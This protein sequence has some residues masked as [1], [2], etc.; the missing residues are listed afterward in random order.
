MG[1]LKWNVSVVCAFIFS[2][3]LVV[4]PASVLSNLHHNTCANVQEEFLRLKIGVRDLVPDKP[5]H[6]AHLAVCGKGLKHPGQRLCCTNATVEK[7]H[8]AA[9]KYLTDS[10]HSGTAFLK[11]FLMDKHQ[12][13]EERSQLFLD[14]AQNRTSVL[15][16]HMHNIP[17]TKH[18]D[19]VKDFFLDLEKYII[20]QNDNLHESVNTFFSK[21]FPSVFYYTLN[22]PSFIQMDDKYHDCLSMHAEQIRPFGKV[23]H[24]LN[25][26]LH[27]SLKRSRSFVS[28]LTNIVEAMNTTEN[29]NIDK[30]CVDAVTRLQYCSRC[31]G[32]TNVKPCHGFCLNVMRGCLSTLSDI[33]PV[34]DTLIVSMENLVSD[35]KGKGNLKN[36][37]MSID[38]SVFDGIL[39]AM[40]GG[41]RIHSKVMEHCAKTTKGNTKHQNYDQKIDTTLMMAPTRDLSH[42]SLEEVIDSVSK[43]LKDSMGMYNRI[44]DGICRSQTAYEQEM[45]S[46]QCWNGTDIGQYITEVPEANFISQAKSN[47]EVRVAVN[48]LPS[49]LALKDKLTQLRVNISSMLSHD[50]MLG[51]DPI[52]YKDMT[53]NSG[54]HQTIFITDDEDLYGSSGSGSGYSVPSTESPPTP[55]I[56]KDRETKKNKPKSS[57][58]IF[59]PSLLLLT[60]LLFFSLH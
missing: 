49:L 34:W 60:I 19:A 55:T 24:E 47:R 27:H 42:L 8:V 7:Y 50:I 46:S 17:W 31:H 26:K 11:K 10:L 35:L 37:L 22:D 1:A 51:D 53:Y 56:Y 57:A 14:E 41:P 36:A 9:N 3:S 48:T 39:E 29:I 5:H 52:D 32:H 23:P 15:L 30:N 59:S 25:K 54:D 45:T 33:S 16:T 21:L 43:R 13:Y 28:L 38:K 12:Q 2:F 20:G 4:F 58:T 18:H 6:V 44:A 40:Q